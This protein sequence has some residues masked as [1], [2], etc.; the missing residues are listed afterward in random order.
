MDK[1]HQGV[2]FKRAHPLNEVKPGR[3]PED[4]AYPGF[5]YRKTVDGELQI[6]RDV[7]VELR[8]GTTIFIDL[9]RPASDEP[10]P[11]LICWNPYGKHSPQ[12]MKFLPGTSVDFSKLSEYTTWEAPDPVLWASRGYA[13]VLPDPRGVFSSEGDASFWNHAEADDEYDLIEWAGTQDWSTGKVGLAGVSYLAISQ[14]FVAS[15]Q[16]P[17][18]AAMNPWEGFS[19]LYREVCFHG[20]IPENGFV[21]WWQEGVEFG[22]NRVEDLPATCAAHPLFDEHWA[23]RTIDFSQIKVPTYV[24]ASWTDQGLHTRGTLEAFKGLGSSSKWL[25]IHGRKKWEYFYRDDCVERQLAFFDT[26]LKGE[27]RGLDGWPAV[28][29]EVRDRSYSGSLHEAGSWPLPN[30]DHQVWYLDA[31]TGTLATV[32]PDSPDSVGYD[33]EVEEAQAT[34]DITFDEEAVLV[35]HAKLKLWIEA[36]GSEDADLFVSLEKLDRNREQVPFPFFSIRDDG[37][38]ALG[39]LRASHRDLDPTRSSP[40]QPWHTHEREIPLEPGEVVPVEVEIWPSGTRF[41]PGESLR[42]VVS[43]RD[44]RSYEHL[45]YNRHSANRNAGRHVIHAGGDFDSHL[46]LPFVEVGEGVAAGPDGPEL[47]PPRK[48][49]RLS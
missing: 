43:A 15:H 22:L 16:P 30:T 4:A 34:F 39:W 49:R 21:P 38:V 2:V 1:R 48:S 24:V 45:P 28:R 3:W 23:G 31:G 11:V 13:M 10:V 20:G 36:E 7:A 46:L 29:F 5:G 32:A 27:E 12:V 17:H 6:E 18:L 42:L 19:D 40:Q 35:G 9:Y 8:D 41:A 44:R 47:T 26:F 14:W 33:C 37:P 25:E